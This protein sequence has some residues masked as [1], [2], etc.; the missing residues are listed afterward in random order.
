MP[1]DTFDLFGERMDTSLQVRDR[2]S[3]R[4]V[5]RKQRAFNKLLAR[6]E[7]LRAECEERK[8]HLEQTLVAFH[9]QIAPRRR[10]IVGLRAEL[11]RA[12]RP[13]RL[14]RRLGAADRRH[15]T[16]VITRQ[17][18]WILQD[19][20]ERPA[21][22][23]V[24]L[25]EEV[26]GVA[27][28]DLEQA[29]VDAAR[30]DFADFCAA[31]G[32]DVDVPDLRIDMSPD[33]VARSTA[34]FAE[35]LGQQLDQ[36]AARE[37][38]RTAG[39]KKSTRQR[40]EEEQQQRVEDARRRSIGVVYKRLARTLHPDLEA[41]ATARV[42]KT[43]LMQQV[44][45]AYKANDL[46]TLL[47]LEAQ[48][49]HQDAGDNRTLAAET[50]DAYT[51][52]L[53]EQVAELEA[54]W[55]ELPLDPRYAEIIADSPLG[56]FSIIDVAAESEILDASAAQIEEAV[57][58]ILANGLE[59]VRLIASAGRPPRRAAQGSRPSRRAPKR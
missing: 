31:M 9:G 51:T 14:D 2:R 17:L 7:Q 44:T 24:A 54:E 55:F 25:F 43:D 50:L 57:A 29:H 4:P 18:D 35:Q 20:D 53:K 42:A 33:E 26:N 40:R 19:S 6:V 37:H 39:R 22:D 59:E 1:S 32:L 52:M 34:Q 12:L 5:D 23:I 11:V 46:H 48:W 49:I 38:A 30:T 47:R 15:L 45:I 21:S 13:Y 58:R 36:A 3:K 27:L 56:P 10:R 28:A 8:R 16:E 41:D